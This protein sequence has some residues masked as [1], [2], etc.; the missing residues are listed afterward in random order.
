MTI[1]F[2]HTLTA[3]KRFM[4]CQINSA[5][6]FLP[7]ST[8]II[9]IHMHPFDIYSHMYIDHKLD[10]CSKNITHFFYYCYAIKTHDALKQGT[11]SGIKLVW[12]N[13]KINIMLDH[14]R[15]KNH[16]IYL[17]HLLCIFIR[18]SLFFFSSSS[19]PYYCFMSAGLP[20]RI[21]GHLLL[22]QKEEIVS[23]C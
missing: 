5:S 23:F 6:I 2:F 17:N 7:Y 9:S 13:K 22:K 11:C 12:F 3:L 14:E 4:F 15:N 16:K 18:S 1:L 8:L 19:S 21:L 20:N 10:K